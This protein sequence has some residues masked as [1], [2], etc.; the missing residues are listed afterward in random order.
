ME[1]YKFEPQDS[2]TLYD[3]EEILE[4]QRGPGGTR[5]STFRV[6]WLVRGLS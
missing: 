1:F 3:V 6:K 4:E 2:E 5:P